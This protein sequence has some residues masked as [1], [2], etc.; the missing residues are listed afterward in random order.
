MPLLENKVCVV[1]GGAG[2]IGLASARLFLREGAK[3]AG[4][5]LKHERA[6]IRG[7]F[8][9]QTPPAYRPALAHCSSWSPVTPLTPAAPMSLPSTK[10]GKPPG[11]STPPE[12]VQE[13]PEMG[14][15]GE[16]A[17]HRTDR[18]PVLDDPGPG[19]RHVADRLGDGDRGVAGQSGAQCG[20]KVPRQVAGERRAGRTEAMPAMTISAS[21][22]SNAVERSMGSNPTS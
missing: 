7:P 21:S 22:A 12:G 14:Q 6:R 11:E 5:R 8:V 20:R 2:S 10:T 18:P 4:S 19:A 17:R 9:L 3:V 1:T 15:G 16:S 13:L